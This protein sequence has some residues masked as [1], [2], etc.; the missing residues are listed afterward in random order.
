MR[1]GAGPAS[2]V[3]ARELKADL[4]VAELIATL[5]S[6][7]KKVTGKQFRAVVKQFVKT[8]TEEEMRYLIRELKETEESEL[9]HPQFPDIVHGF[10]KKMR[11]YTCQAVQILEKTSAAKLFHPDFFP[12]VD[13]ISM[14]FPVSVSMPQVIYALQDIEEAQ[15]LHPETLP[16]AR[17]LAAEGKHGMEIFYGLKEFWKTLGSSAASTREEAIVPSR[18]LSPKSAGDEVE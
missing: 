12:L 10:A 1:G 2:D 4:R 9:F 7:D 13:V 5:E 15:L 17:A 14:G 3:D 6:S 18:S 8:E 11:I 16:T